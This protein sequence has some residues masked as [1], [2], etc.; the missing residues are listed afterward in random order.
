MTEPQAS[1]LPRLE[2]VRGLAGLSVAYWHCSVALAFTQFP[3]A[4]Q[5]EQ[6]FHR[7]VLAPIGWIANGWAAMIM[8]F[9]LSGLVLSL[10]IERSRS[11]RS[12][13]GYAG[14]VWRR[15]LRIYP[16][17]IVALILFVP[18]AWLIFKLPV[19]DPAALAA[20]REGPS[21]WVN[22]IVYGTFSWP[23][24]VST[25]TLYS[26]Y[27]NPLTW[28]LQVEVVGSVLMPFFY[29]LARPRRAS[30][31]GGTLAALVGA[32]FLI[33]TEAAP[34]SPLLYLPAFYLGCMARTHGPA[35]AAAIGRWRH[36]HATGLGLSFL[37]LVGPY[38]FVPPHASR[39]CILHMTMVS[40]VL[41][42][43]IAWG[44][45]RRS[46]RLLDH[47][48]P[49]WLGRISYSFY[50]WHMLIVFAFTRLLFAT[51]PPDILARGTHL[52]LGGTIIV[53][54]SAALV[55]AALSQRWIETP[56]IAFGKRFPRRK[57]VRSVVTA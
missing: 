14:F 47:P 38:A 5:Y 45:G 34:A 8:F 40:F 50:L 21:P 57:S 41:I 26:N 28:S 12:F 51:V 56:F 19:L 23:N 1:Y 20:S 48:V 15:G 39:A 54:F 3:L 16:A 53:T 11:D 33:D 13:A 31:D 52:V 27:Y 22:G 30:I 55:A 9:V 49:R 25:A 44:Q 36:G 29:M 4:G 35:L 18:A 6:A 2:S 42:S 43:L 24:W 46:A 17:H 7:F 37:L 10:A 32:T